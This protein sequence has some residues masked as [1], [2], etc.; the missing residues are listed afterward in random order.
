MVHRARRGA[1]LRI[2]RSG[3]GGVGRAKWPCRGSLRMALRVAHGERAGLLAWMAA[4]QEK[5][6]AAIDGKEIEA[7]KERH[8]K[9]LKKLKRAI[10]DAASGGAA[11]T[12][13]RHSAAVSVD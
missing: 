4:L 2:A 7:V 11:A 10:K 6:S 3:C 1:R 5:H 9:C 13:D 8:A 12:D